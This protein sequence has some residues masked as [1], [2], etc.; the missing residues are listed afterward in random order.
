MKDLTRRG[1]L[2]S[3]AGV[4]VGT[5]ITRGSGL[6]PREAIVQ[7]SE[8]GR[9][10]EDF[11]RSQLFPAPQEMTSSG[12]DF[13]LGN[14]VRVVVPSDATEEDLRCAWQLI[15]E[16]GDRFG[17][18]L[19]LARLANLNGAGRVI[20][21]GSVGNPLVRQ[22]CSEMTLTAKVE[23]LG[24]EGYILRVT[25]KVVLIAGHD[26]RG[27]FYGLQSLRQLVV[28]DEGALRV[29]GVLIR[30]WPDKPFRGMYMYVPGRDNIPFFKRF[31]RDFM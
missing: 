11:L 31:V 22:S 2:N 1:F 8:N 12:S 6:L 20:L 24:T 17:L 30:D 5:T 7:Q 27:A 28:N 19:K 26:D 4:A 29:R 3:M 9:S 13:A 16:L 21:M 25:E 18:H 23:S 10:G 15:N 14:D